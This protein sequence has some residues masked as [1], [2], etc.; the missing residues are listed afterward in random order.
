M[1]LPVPRQLP[2]KMALAHWPWPSCRSL[3]SSFS[4]CR[5]I[6]TA[7]A[8]SRLTTKISQTGKVVAGQLNQTFYPRRPLRIGGTRHEVEP[9]TATRHHYRL[10]AGSADLPGLEINGLL[11]QWCRAVDAANPC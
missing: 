11:V 7:E 6:T 4:H 2:G 9:V 3:G 8:L 1:K 5:L 10:G